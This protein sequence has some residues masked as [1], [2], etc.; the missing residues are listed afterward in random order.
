M[1][2][3]G[4]FHFHVSLSLLVFSP[5]AGETISGFLFDESWPRRQRLNSISSAVGTVTKTS[6]SHIGLLIHDIFNASIPVD[7]IPSAGYEYDEGDK[8][9]KESIS[10]KKVEEG[11]VMRFAVHRWVEGQF[12]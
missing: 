3:N 9:W 4:Y 8:C 11:S 10:G 2:D 7:N 1:Y 5:K 6:R 12:N